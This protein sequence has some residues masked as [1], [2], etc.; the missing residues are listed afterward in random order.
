MLIKFIL[1]RLISDFI[2]TDLISVLC[3]QSALRFVAATVNWVVR[4][5]ATQFAAAATNH[6][7]L[8]SDEMRSDKVRRGEVR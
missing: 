1:S 6:G 7:A 4:C 8:G 5:E 2:S 3:E